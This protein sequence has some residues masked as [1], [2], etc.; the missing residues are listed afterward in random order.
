LEPHAIATVCG[1][2]GGETSGFMDA[3]ST[4]KGVPATP[5]SLKSHFLAN[6]I[7]KV[8]NRPTT[9]SLRLVIQNIVDRAAMNYVT[10]RQYAVRTTC[11]SNTCPLC[12]YS[13]LEAAYIGVEE[14]RQD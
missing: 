12:T 1:G 10:H 2:V 13:H 14:N 4:G 3:R 11:S 7:M 9:S 5:S 6:H 8:N